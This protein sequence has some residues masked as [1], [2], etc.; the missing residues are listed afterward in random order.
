[1]DKYRIKRN[2]QLIVD[3]YPWWC[4]AAA[5]VLGFLVGMQ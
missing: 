1:M 3:D 5:F 2:I 4:M